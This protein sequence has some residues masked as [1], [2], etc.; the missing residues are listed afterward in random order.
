M[1]K[2]MDF[3]LMHYTWQIQNIFFF[4]IAIFRCICICIFIPIYIYKN[5]LHFYR[6]FL[7]FGWIKNREIYSQNSIC[8]FFFSFSCII[9]ID[10]VFGDFVSFFLV[11]LYSMLSYLILSD[12][13]LKVN[14][15]TYM[16]GVGVWWWFFFSCVWDIQ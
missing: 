3:K 12:W 13:R 5:K 4:F 1:V 14:G 8:C 15:C 7:H 11:F 2:M 16:E 6:I 9:W 10:Y